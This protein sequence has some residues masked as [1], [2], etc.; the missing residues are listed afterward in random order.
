MLLCS[1]PGR[2]NGFLEPAEPPGCPR[3][4]ASG[5]LEKFAGDLTEKLPEKLAGDPPETFAGD[6]PE[7]FAG[8]PPE[9]FAGDPPENL[10][11]TRRRLSPA[12]RPE[13]RRPCRILAGDPPEN[14]PETGRRKS[15]KITLFT[16]T[17]RRRPPDA[18]PEPSEST[19]RA[20]FGGP[21]WA[22][23]SGRVF[24]FKTLRLGSSARA[25][26]SPSPG[27]R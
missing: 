16:K 21:V 9:T 20:P 6:P 7:T 4:G 23:F 27:G 8:D 25:R 12:T 22:L 2:P 13:N 24:F 26:L 10:P 14:L 11:E 15:T 3:S 5:D 17:G 1:L 18:Q 19:L